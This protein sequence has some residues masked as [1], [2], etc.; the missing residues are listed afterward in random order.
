MSDERIDIEV[1]DKVSPAVREKILGIATAARTADSALD[2]LKR[3][4]AA[5]DATGV[6]K[7]SNA[8]A[9]LTN[10]LAREMNAQ[11][12]LTTA[13]IRQATE[14]GKAALAKQKL[15]TEA[16]RTAVAEARLAA[17]MSRASNASVQAAGAATRYETALLRL[18]AAQDKAAAG[19]ANI[20]RSGA[21][22]SGGL[23]S[24]AQSALTAVG[25]YIGGREILAAADAYT[26]LENK[27]R[28]VT[29][30]ARQLTA[31][32]SEL[33]KIANETRA[34][35]ADTA[36]SFQRFD[37]AMKELGASQRETLDLTKTL[38]QAIQLS[39]ATTSEAQSGMIQLAQAFGSGKLQGDEFR[40]IMENLP[41]V[42]DI[43]AKQ[44]KV[45]R[46]ELKQMA[47]DGKITAEVMRA[48]F[49]AARVEIGEK[50]AKS[51]PTLAQSMSVLNNNFVQYVG[52]VDKATGA[53]SMLSQGVLG[54]ANNM[55]I[56]A[57]AMAALGIVAISFSSAI[58]GGFGAA[59]A[60]V[61]TFTIAL[62]TN[63]VGILIVAV[64]AAIALLYTFR[65]SLFV[66]GDGVTTLGDLFRALW[67]ITVETFNT[68]WA[69]AQAFF[70]PLMELARPVIET[71]QG[72]FTTFGENVDLTFRGIVTFV[73]K[74]YDAIIGIGVGSVKAMIAAWG[75]FPGAFADLILRAVNAGI[76]LME[77]FVNGAIALLNKLIGAFNAI[78]DNELTR[79]LGINFTSLNDI[80]QVSFG[81]IENT[82]AGGFQNLG[83]STRDAFLEGFNGSNGLVGAVNKVFDRAAAIGQNRLE[84]A[85]ETARGNARLSDP[86]R[87]ASTP[88]KK[89]KEAEDGDG[90][91]AKA[92]KKRADA[93][94]KINRELDS[95]IARMG[96]LKPQREIQQ[97]LDQYEND[98]LSKKI[99]LT[100]DEKTALKSKLE[101]IQN[102][103]LVQQ[104]LD[105]IYGETL[106]KE[107][108][109]R[110]A[111]LATAEAY[112]LGLISADA[113][114]NRLV[115]LQSQI[116]QV[117][118]EAGN[119][120]FADVFSASLGKVVESYK[121]MLAGLSDSFGNF[122]TSLNQ[123]FG[124]AIGNAITKGEN[125]GDALRNVAQQAVSKLISSLVQ[126][127]VQYLLTQALG[128][129]M[130]T[131]T[132][133][134]QVASAGAATAAQVAGAATATAAQVAGTATV[135][136]ANAAQTAAAVVGTATQTATAVAGTATTTAAAVTGAATTAAAQVAA[137]GV[138]TTAAVA[139]M[140][141]TTTASVASATAT[142][143]AWA[144][145]AAFASIGSFGTAALLGL[146][147][148]AAVIA[149]VS[150]GFEK[151]GYTGG[152]GRKDI[153]GVV[154]GKEFVMNADAT[155]RN[156]R[157]L[158][159]MNSGYD[160]AG[161]V[162]GY[163]T[164]G[165]VEP[166]YSGQRTQQP[167]ASNEGRSNR[168]SKEK[169]SN[170][171]TVN[172]N[173]TTQDA[174]SFVASEGQ[175]AAAAARAIQRGTRNL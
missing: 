20:A 98:L 120:S 173:L 83:T 15:A 151:G 106:G 73:A 54:I 46:G 43:L 109:L 143:A 55:N 64:T 175:V 26:T 53:T 57:P 82:Y 84:L 71:V 60:A 76:K 140:A 170:G 156:R 159:A 69:A 2:K 95:E 121:G 131:T 58:V 149:L 81:K 49:A 50:F 99:K 105:T 114:G 133:A 79:K 112:K 101:Q 115:K 102:L 35:V 4:L 142:G 100:A 41:V 22:A 36:T 62:L 74:Y 90:K 77:D 37:M 31:V 56:A 107:T 165:Y 103:K 161:L 52:Q 127:G 61:R 104:Q 160:V 110:A 42:A 14:D 7:L 163:M 145:A 154:H 11:A 8:S 28:T 30:S 118:L 155:A 146:A 21:G 68:M 3:Q 108:E 96:M 40:S 144:P 126:L 164:G 66:A 162:P 1:Q 85:R 174:K 16:A 171:V 157:L 80:A 89:A 135:T 24:A 91:A 19:N 59:T 136:A 111:T 45:T 25:S 97:Q 150:K 65:D 27:L 166:A 124:D 51:V 48:A 138:A 87:G 125:L 113:Y 10:A 153:A 75:A 47:T 6:E 116:A 86:L 139:G 172:L 92:A 169:G 32:Q 33:F 44:L 137:T 29:D 123:G 128:I 129:G 38:N 13:T 12:R 141:T 132:G 63:P 148:I 23:A 147:G 167:P 88:A 67:E 134:A 17:E 130:A 158:E 152:G 78:G 5:I 70:T 72:W 168:N 18:K 34:P 122:F 117:K 93:I 39:G 119:G 94:A 9:K